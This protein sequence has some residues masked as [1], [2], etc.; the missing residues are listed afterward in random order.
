MS[1]FN[2]V[3]VLYDHIKS[4][5]NTINHNADLFNIYEG[6]LLSFVIKDLKNQLSA[7]SFDIA[8]SRIPP[9]NILQ[10]LVDKLSKIYQQQPMR[11]V[12]TQIDR[13]KE[14][15][16][17]YET[18]M[19]FNATMN[20]SN[21]F[22][23]LYKNNLIMPYVYRGKPG[24][25]SIS[26]DMF[27][28]YSDSKVQPNKPTHLIT[29][30][31]IKDR[32]GYDKDVYYTYTDDEFMIFDSDKKIRYD[33]MAESNNEDGV[34]VFGKIPAIYINRSKNLLIPKPDTD[35]KKMSVLL[36]VM[37]ADL[38]FAVM[39]QAFSILYGIDL[40]NEGMTLSPN[41]FWHFRS[42]EDSDKK[43]EIGVL[44]PQV[45]I[46]PTLELIQSQISMWLQTR[47]IKPGS[48]G[49]LT[50]DNF[51]SGI[52]KL[53]DEMDTSEE[54]QKQVAVYSYAESDFWN[55][56]VNHMHPVWRSQSLIDSRLDWT[57]GAEIS[58]RFHEQLPILNRGDIVADMKAEVD[59][60][61]TTR[62]R[63]IKK[64][65]PR[66]SDEDIESLIVEIDTPEGEAAISD[67]DAVVLNGAQV[68][69]V[70]TVVKDVAAGM[71]PRD[72]GIHIIMTSFNLSA[73][74]AESIMGSAGQGFKISLDDIKGGGL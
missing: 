66:M 59:A 21:E 26:S 55:L 71:L 41:A 42:N 44:K 53:I 22:Y 47:G 65:N 57:P 33:L 5:R 11:Y 18:S 29:F 40:N 68:T 14:L 49:Q 31:C 6:D 10:R 69:A 19:D 39:M 48:V 72:A 24:L 16:S 46:Q 32:D 17:Y 60:G 51:A 67:K 64:L 58:T 70:V 45:D 4:Q 43:P 38:N 61:F 62:R 63:A 23:N 27:T 37:L 8:K 74:Q 15:L 50:Q 20:G 3:D 2:Q 73:E 56:I 12:N 7:Q 54:R 36:P 9:I 34:N 13:D 52:S 30:H 28:V 1:L 25:R 35:V